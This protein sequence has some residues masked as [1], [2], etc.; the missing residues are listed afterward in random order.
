MCEIGDYHMRWFLTS[1][2]FQS[3]CLTNIKILHGPQIAGRNSVE[4]ILERTEHTC[5]GMQFV[6]NVKSK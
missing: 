1:N 6:N 2:K 5:Q 4:L 3:G